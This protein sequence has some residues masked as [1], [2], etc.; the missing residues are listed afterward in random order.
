MGAALE[1]F[2]P[3]ADHQ[4][5]H[6]TF[7]EASPRP[8]KVMC[9]QQQEQDVRNVEKVAHAAMLS[10]FCRDVRNGWKTDISVAGQ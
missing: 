3:V 7:T 6:D 4:A 9:G 10:Y 8:D 5:V 2:A 1:T